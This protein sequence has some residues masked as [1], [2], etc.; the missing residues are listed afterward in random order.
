MLVNVQAYLII[1]KAIAPGDHSQAG[2]CWPRTL[3]VILEAWQLMIIPSQHELPLAPNINLLIVCGK[4]VG[5]DWYFGYL[6]YATRT[7][8][9]YFAVHG[10]SCSWAIWEWGISLQISHRWA[11]Y[12]PWKCQFIRSYQQI[13]Q[14]GTASTVAEPVTTVDLQQSHEEQIKLPSVLVLFVAGKN[15]KHDPYKHAGSS[16]WAESTVEFSPVDD[17][18]MPKSSIS[19]H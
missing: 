1:L 11:K 19:I 18:V 9:P 7:Y 3:C 12:L 15:T 2:H 14:G 10:T 17:N 16:F 13:Q 8:F 5:R 4:V 6:W